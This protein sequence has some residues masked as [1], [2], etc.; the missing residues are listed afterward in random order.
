MAKAIE[1]I[2]DTEVIEDIQ[3]EFN[4]DN[5]EELCE[6]CEIENEIE[7]TEEESDEIVEN[8]SEESEGE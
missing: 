1:E 8:E 7:I 3:T 2:K 5:F 4:E 6:E